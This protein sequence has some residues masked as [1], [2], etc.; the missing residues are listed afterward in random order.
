MDH[1]DAAAGRRVVMDDAA[2]G[3][4]G[5]EEEGDELGEVLVHALT[6]Q[7]VSG[8]GTFSHRVADTENVVSHGT[9]DIAFGSQLPVPL[10]VSFV[11][12]SVPVNA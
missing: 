9:A 7:H 1:G 3:D 5:D 10:I 12:V 4:A 2:S 8:M 11:A 6:T